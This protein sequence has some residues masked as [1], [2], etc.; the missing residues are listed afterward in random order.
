MY[1]ESRPDNLIADGVKFHTFV[2]IVSFA[3]RQ[4]V[5]N[6]HQS[7]AYDRQP[8]RIQGEQSEPADASA[9]LLLTV[10]PVAKL[11][12]NI[13]K[14]LTRWTRRGIDNPSDAL[15]EVRGVEIWQISDSLVVQFET[16]DELRTLAPV[17]NVL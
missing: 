4:V 7:V 11:G 6:L 10:L 12:A 14:K 15:T 1:F 13:S 17:L 9:P 16:C 3:L 2:S 8:Y 5:R